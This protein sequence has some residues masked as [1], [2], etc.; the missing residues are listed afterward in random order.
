MPELLVDFQR[1]RTELLEQISQLG[2]FRA[3]CV[4]A[5]VRRCGKAGCRCSRPG[6]P[7]HGPNLRLTFK[8]KGKTYSKSL[9]NPAAQ[10]KVQKEIAEFRKF[11]VFIREYVELNGRMCC[12]LPAEPTSDRRIRRRT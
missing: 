10:R 8:I 9:A 12:L 7:G 3:G 5:L 2:N 11:Q 1:R 6:D 4:T